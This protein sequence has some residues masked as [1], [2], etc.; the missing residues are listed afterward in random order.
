M[1]RLLLALLLGAQ[2]A[3]APVAAAPAPTLALAGK[4]TING[5]SFT[6]DDTKHQA[7]FS[8]H[9]VVTHTQLNLTA[10]QVVAFY[11]AAGASSIKSFEATG[12]VKIVTKEQTAT[13]DRAV[14]DP[15]TRLL[16]LTGNVVVDSASGEVKS[17][18]LLVDLNKNTSVFSGTKSGGRVTGVFTSQ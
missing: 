4:I 3:A 6:V 16:H 5:D 12:H 2:M 17:S 14:F 13:G 18:E 8:G 10:D 15:K 1:R 7:T 11:G 9:V